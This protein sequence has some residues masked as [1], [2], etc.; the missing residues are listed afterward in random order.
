MNDF[1]GVEL[2]LGDSVI[3][4]A[5]NYRH[6]VLARIIKF[7]PMQVRVAFMNTWNYAKP[8]YYTE[9]LQSPSQLTKVDGPD[10]TAHLSRK[11]T[12]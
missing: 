6:F 1:L 5:P 7:T 12:A 4:M 10:L 8:G 11:E 3:I 2:A 9:L